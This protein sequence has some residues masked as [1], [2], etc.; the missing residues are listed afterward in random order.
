[1]LIV[2]IGALIQTYFENEAGVKTLEAQKVKR[3]VDDLKA[4]NSVLE[5]Q[6]LKESSLQVIADK[7]ELMGFQEGRMILLMPEEFP[8]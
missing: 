7:A 2:V 8:R 6:V 1:M 3:R 4:K 5:Q